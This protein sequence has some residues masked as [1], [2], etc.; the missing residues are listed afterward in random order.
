M[1]NRFCVIPRLIALPMIVLGSAAILSGC[2]CERCDYTKATDCFDL[3]QSGGQV[4]S[5]D[6]CKDAV[7]CICPSE[8]DRNTGT[9]DVPCVSENGSTNCSDCDNLNCP[10]CVEATFQL[11]VEACNLDAGGGGCEG[12]CYYRKKTA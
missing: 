4:G 11:T 5:T 8:I 2:P 10:K 12:T 7:A 3:H 6:T 1:R 9:F